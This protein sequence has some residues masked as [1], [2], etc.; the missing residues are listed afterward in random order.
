VQ[1]LDPAALATHFDVVSPDV[2]LALRGFLDLATRALDRLGCVPV[3][4]S[5]EPASLPALYL[6]GLEARQ[7][8]EMRDARDAAEGVWAE[9]LGAMETG[10]PEAPTGPQLLLNYRNPL[11]RRVTTVTDPV[12]VALALEALYSQALLQSHRPMRPVDVATLNRS[13]LGLLEWAIHDPV[14]GA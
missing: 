7:R 9:I 12:L 3:I 8:V 10:D 13:F 14:G 1:R 2:D 4:R 11:V 6:E 5:Y